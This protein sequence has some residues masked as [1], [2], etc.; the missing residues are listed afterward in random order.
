MNESILVAMGLRVKTGKAIAVLLRGPVKSPTVIKRGELLLA[1]PD[2]PD[3]WQ[4]YHV[5][6]D[7][8]WKEAQR[9]ALRTTGLIRAAGSEAVGNWARE[10]RESGL[11]LCGV[12]IVAGSL[13][14][15][16]KVGNPHIRAHTAEGQLFREALEMAADS[17][18][19]SRY[20]FVEEKIYEAGAPELACS[21]EALKAR[22]SELGVAVGRPWR[23][24]EKAATAAA[25]VMLA[26]C[27]RK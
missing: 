15:P 3:T 17:L 5:V 24:L 4:P 19:L 10:V 20:C 11:E 2:E 16:S 22:V 6:M 1:D 26:R 25:W 7:L 23:A 12:G 18:S 13:E 21:A 9:A 27:A 8:P 14:D